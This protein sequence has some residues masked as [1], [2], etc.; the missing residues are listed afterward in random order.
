MQAIT[1][2]GF[3]IAKSVSQ[4]HGACGKGLVFSRQSFL[5]DQLVERQLI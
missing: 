1:T 4:V 2:A 3:D 5:Q